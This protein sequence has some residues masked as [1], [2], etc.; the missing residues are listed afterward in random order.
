MDYT[1][2]NE[3]MARKIGWKKVSG[4][5][6]KQW[7]LEKYGKDIDGCTYADWYW[8]DGVGYRSELPSFSATENAIFMAV[9][10]I[11]D[12]Y[13]PIYFYLITDFDESEKQIWVANFTWCDECG[14]VDGST[15]RSE[16]C[17]DAIYDAI[18]G[19]PTQEK[20]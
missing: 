8:F 10:A 4:E 12:T 18:M 20:V 15:A 11:L 1:Q 5:Q 17:V 16:N 7:S 14:P 19:I 6:V 2:K 9:R 3:A 13:A